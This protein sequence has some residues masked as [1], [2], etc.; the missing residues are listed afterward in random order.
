[1]ETNKMKAIVATG[2]GN[3]EVL[4]LSTVAKPQPEAHEVLVKVHATSATTADG[5]MLSGKPYFARLFTGLRKPKNPIPGTGFAGIVESVGKA[6]TTFRVGECVFG[7][8]T[9]SFSTNAEY[10]AVP[11]NGVILTMPDNLSFTDAATFCDGHLTS[12]N[13]LKEIAQIKAGQ[14]VLIN[15]AS[16]SLGTAAVQLAK[17]FGAEVTGV[18]SSANVGLVKSLGADHVMDYNK[19]DFTRSGQKYDVI[20]DTVGKSAFSKSKRVL[21][22]YGIYISPVLKFS[23]LLQ[24]I[25]TSIAGR[26]KAKF[27]AS[28]LK[29]DNELRA[30]LTELVGIF[31]AGKLKT[32]IDRQFPLERLAQAHAYIAGGHKKGNVVINVQS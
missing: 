29:S 25:R 20:Y 22:E 13:F 5:M 4:Q 21:S 27:A 10:V 26:Q 17:Y 32:I 12:I 15:G 23:L 1:M 2:Y 18:C 16:G 6:V 30:L 7:E 24:M 19:Q 3:A 14:K 8:T 31:Q 9:L 11:E 28:G